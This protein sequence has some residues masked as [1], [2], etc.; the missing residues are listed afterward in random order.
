MAWAFEKESELLPLFNYYLEKLQQ[1]GVMD[2]LR[3]KMMHFP[4]GNTDSLKLQVQGINGLGYEHVVLPFLALMI[5]LCLAFVQLG[6]ETAITRK[7]SD[8][9]EQSIEVESKSEYT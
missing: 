8:N 2:R 1:T 6:A 4:R 7:C 9:K 5:G 3:Q